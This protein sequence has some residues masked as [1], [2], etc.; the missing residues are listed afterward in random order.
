M[1]QVETD[2]K[3]TFK[4]TKRR[5][6]FSVF[7]VL[8]AIA[9]L[10]TVIC[11]QIIQVEAYSRYMGIKTVS[12]EKVSKII[13]GI[14]INANNVFEE[15]S[16]SLDSSEE[17]VAALKSKAALNLD[18]RGYFAAFTPNYFPEKGEWFEPYVFQPDYGGFEYRQIGSARH[19][20]T[21]SGWY[22]RAKE[23]SESFWADPYYYYDGTS[24][25]G[26][27]TTFIKPIYD[28]K[29]DLACVCG[30]DMKFEWLAKEL[31]WIDESNKSSKILNKFKIT[32]DPNFY[33]VIL[34]KDGT[35]LAHPEEMEVSINDSIILRELQQRKSGIAN[36]NINGEACTVIYGP[37]EFIDWSVAVVVPQ[38]DI[39]KPMLPI[40]IL[41]FS[42]VIVGM[43]IVWF[44]C[45]R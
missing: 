18:V 39:I 31:K 17:V 16:E 34:N 6:M 8:T 41:L 27:Y 44:I 30:A 26:H 25:S 29:G 22:I 20:Y 15:I 43:I 37:V 19:N 13:R 3:K 1:E 28:A 35:C 7:V 10:A 33:T 14:E 21:K 4:K 5:I 32:S 11:Y 40:A 42:M 45:K 2:L 9:S 12:T 36:T 24:M 23:K 38:K